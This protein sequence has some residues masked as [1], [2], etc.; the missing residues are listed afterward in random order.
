MTDIYTI[1]MIITIAVFTLTTHI[2]PGPTNIILLSSVLN[3]GYKRSLPFMIGNI[4]SYPIMMIFTGFGFGLLLTQ[5]PTMMSILKVFGM[6]YL[7]FMAWKIFKDT[8]TYDTKKAVEKEP[9][10]FWQSLI[11]PW[12]NPKAWIVYSSTISVF[13]TSSENSFIQMSIIVF[14]IFISMVITVYAWAFGGVILKKFMKNE[15]F[16][17]RINQTMA[18]LLVASIIPILIN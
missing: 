13:I 17:K 1:S 10:T 14:F 5:H 15:K 11:Y 16:I 2:T 7:C 6:A 9:F 4:I 8:H 18:I 3:F 12:L